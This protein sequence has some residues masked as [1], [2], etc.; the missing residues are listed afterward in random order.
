M[1]NRPGSGSGFTLIEMV[2]TISAI[3]IM[4]AVG[5]TMISDNLQVTMNVNAATASADQARYAMERISRE[6]REVSYSTSAGGG[7]YS[8]TSSLAANST[9]ISF[10]RNINGVTPTNETLFLDGGSLKLQYGTDAASTLIGN[11]TGF[12]V[13]FYGFNEGGVS[14]ST[15]LTTTTVRYVV[16][17]LTVSDPTSGQTITQRMNVALRNA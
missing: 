14:V 12:G 7:S 8:I 9:S 17:S 1:L 10:T 5:A 3:G 11:V 2:I 15:G 13:T 16:V 4:A 6:L